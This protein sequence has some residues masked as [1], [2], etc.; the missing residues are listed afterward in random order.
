MKEVEIRGDKKDDI[1][2]TK[3]SDRMKEETGEGAIVKVVGH[4]G[5]TNKTSRCSPRFFVGEVK[6]SNYLFLSNLF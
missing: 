4:E 1:R 6:R 3:D 2:R 5:R